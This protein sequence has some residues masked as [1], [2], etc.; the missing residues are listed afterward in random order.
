MTAQTILAPLSDGLRRTVLLTAISM[1][2]FIVVLA[3]TLISVVAVAMGLMREALFKAL[4][5]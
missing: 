4:R 5:R 3:V 1:A 2:F